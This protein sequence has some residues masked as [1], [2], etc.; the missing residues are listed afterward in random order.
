MADKEPILFRIPRR[1]PRYHFGGAAELTDESGQS[2]VAMVRTLSL[3]GCFVKT[4]KRLRVGTKISLR[5]TNAGSQF[6]ATARIASQASNGS[7][8]E[9]AEMS[10][11][12]KAQLE[13]NLM[14]LAGR[15]GLFDFAPN[16]VP[17]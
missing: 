4:D 11:A 2:F 5:I 14:Q 6:A 10:A 17:K 13:S 1:A 16:G 9:F 3:Y 15:D 7:G 8:V 12:D